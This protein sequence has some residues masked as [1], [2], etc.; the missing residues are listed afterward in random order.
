MRLPLFGLLFACALV[1]TF[2]ILKVGM[3]GRS[4]RRASFLVALSAAGILL[5]GLVSMSAFEVV[6]VSNGT[7]LT[8]SYPSLAVVGVIGAAVCLYSL[9]KSAVETIS[10]GGMST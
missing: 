4:S 7:E 9:A 10:F 8:Y 2:V 6:T 1:T 5:W 3:D